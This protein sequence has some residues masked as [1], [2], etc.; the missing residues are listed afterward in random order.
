MKAILL[1]ED[2]PQGVTAEM[3]WQGNGCCDN[4]ET[5]VTMHTMANLSHFMR[6]MALS[7][8]VRVLNEKETYDL[9][10]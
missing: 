3:R 8:G 5:S 7:G 10:R 4:H 9:G 1:L 2:T 6:R